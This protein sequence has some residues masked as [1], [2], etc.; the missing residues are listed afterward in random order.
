[1]NKFGF[2]TAWIFASVTADDGADLATLLGTADSLNHAIPT[3][4]EV[5]RGLKS[6]HACGLINIGDSLIQ[7]TSHGR[8]VA[9]AGYARR[10]GRFAIPDNMR[11]SLDAALHPE[12]DSDPDL[13]FITEES[14]SAAY[15]TYRKML[16]I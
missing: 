16:R 11:K 3:F 9:D 14:L 12:I 15:E 8:A 1:M 7:L 6:L 2:T 10:G 4:E 13:S 5:T